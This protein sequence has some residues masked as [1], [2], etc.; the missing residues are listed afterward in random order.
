[1]LF[2]DRNLIILAALLLQVGQI[3]D[4]MDGNLARYRKQTTLR[5]GFLDRILDGTG[6]IFVMSGFS[7]LTYQKG[8]E[9]YYLLLG[10]MAAAFYLVVCYVYWTTAYQEQKHIG[11]SKKVNPGSNAKAIYHIPTWKYILKG[12]KKLFSI[13][14]ADFY[15]WV[16]LGLVLEI[17]EYIIWLLFVVLFIRVLNRIKSRYQYLKLL[18][19]GSF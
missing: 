16:G 11:K 18:D 17:S 5:G 13:H 12:Q 2:I 10:P 14:Q 8:N 19:R 3:L 6:F 1:M 9:P 7:W 15:F 4:S